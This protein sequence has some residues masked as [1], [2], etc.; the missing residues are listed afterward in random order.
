MG[1]SRASPAEHVSPSGPSMALPTFCCGLQALPGYFGIVYDGANQFFDS[2]EMLDYAS[3]A[4]SV[5]VA[6]LLC[7]FV[8]AHSHNETSHHLP[9]AVGTI[10]GLVE[11]CPCL[12]SWIP[13]RWVTLCARDLGQGCNVDEYHRASNGPRPSEHPISQVLSLSLFAS[14]LTAVG[15]HLLRLHSLII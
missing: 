9:H 2:P 15:C 8:P 3:Y 4:D 10:R 6:C 7:R 12:A 5:L 14:A 1:P 13:N 11:S